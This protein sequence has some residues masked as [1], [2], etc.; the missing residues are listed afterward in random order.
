WLQ[1]MPDV[2]T[3]HVPGIDFDRN[4]ASVVLGAR[5]GVWGLQSNF[6]VTATTAQK[7]ASDMSFFVNFSGAF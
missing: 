5:T 6:G 7:G 1:T 4:Y 3:F 2:G